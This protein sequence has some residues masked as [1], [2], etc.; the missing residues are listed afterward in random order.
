MRLML[1]IIA[2]CFTVGASQTAIARQYSATALPGW[3]AVGRLNISDKYMCT[4]TLVA[5]NLVLTA[6]HCVYDAQTGRRFKPQ[7]IRFEA[8]L[9]GRRV[10]AARV[11]DK[12]VVHPS[13]EFRTGG[14][15]Q[16]GHDIAVLRLSSP[17]SAA[18]V[19][20]FHMLG[21]ADRGTSVNVLSYSYT[22]ATRPSL[23]QGCE[24]LSR[25]AR[26]LVM[27]CQVDFG[28]SG[29]PVLEVLPG[30]PPRIVSVISS[31][32]AMGQRRVS[33]GTTLDSTLRAMMR[34]AG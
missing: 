28:A 21:E 19:R 6:A 15:Y 23:E 16:L 10:K 7:R 18:E 22:H 25:R 12:A 24:V 34:S 30:S 32:A 33:I 9:D 11:V 20:P 1:A 4:G 2:A 8:G 13:Y 5:P 31:K 27:S 29:A 26:T 14:N 17:I 3:E